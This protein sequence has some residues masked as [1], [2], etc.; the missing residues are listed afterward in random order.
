[1]PRMPRRDAPGVLHHVMLRGVGQCDIFRDDI[2]RA[3]FLDRLR[4]VLRDCDLALLAFAF[5]SNHVHLVLRTGSIPLARAMARIDTGHALYFNRRHQRVGHLFQNRYKAAQIEDDAHLR[6]AIRYVHANPLE[7]RLVG[8]LAALEVFPW[9]GHAILA[10]ACQSDFLDVRA[11]LA[12]F[13]DS[14]AS[15]RLALREFMREWMAPLPLAPEPS[16]AALRLPQL[17]V[18][19]TQVAIEFGVNPRDI[20]AGSRR[21]EVSRARAELARRAISVHRLPARE[22]A[23]WLGVTHPAV[24]RGAARAARDRRAR[25]SP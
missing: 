20:A 9:T 19:L 3:N 13:G 7:A 22:V 6:N 12:P 1:M 8:S 15:A 23:L 21:R 16:P 24:L 4:I 11:A 18:E 10:G 25:V 5:M 2:D 14:L 17:E